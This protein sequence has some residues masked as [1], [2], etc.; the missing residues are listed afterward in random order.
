MT[1][2]PEV[3]EDIINRVCTIVECR[4]TAP[5]DLFLFKDGLSI[6]LP[7]S[8]KQVKDH[9]N[10]TDEVR[11]VLSK[12]YLVFNQLVPIKWEDTK[13]LLTVHGH[14]SRLKQAGTS[15]SPDGGST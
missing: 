1:Q 8:K 5:R 15:G 12:A 13:G 6:L 7:H 3:I 10:M 11:H 4:K 9:S 2:F 14:R